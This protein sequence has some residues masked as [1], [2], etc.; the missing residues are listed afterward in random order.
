MSL[1]ICITKQQVSVWCHTSYIR[2][3]F[4][5][6][7]TFMCILCDFLCVYT[8]MS[9]GASIDQK[10]VLDP[11]VLELQVERNH[12]TWVQG[13]N[14]G[15]LEGQQA[16]LINPR[17]LS[18]AHI[19][20]SSLWCVTHSSRPSFG[21]HHSVF[22]TWTTLVFSRLLSVSVSVFSHLSTCWPCSALQE[23]LSSL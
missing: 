19:N 22:V 18:L 23:C 2:I 8:H 21:F 1:Q 12:V 17:A 9:A 16:L 13:Q 11:L 3:F 4:F 6:R 7:F 20:S 5:K 10:R 14:L 15:L